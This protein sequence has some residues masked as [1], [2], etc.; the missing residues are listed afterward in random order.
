MHATASVRDLETRLAA[1]EAALAEAENAAGTAR[2]QAALAQA[3][4]ARAQ[5]ALEAAEALVLE[6]LQRPAGLL[7]DDAETAA[8]VSPPT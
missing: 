1:A 4:R 3:E 5:A 8:A 2:E 6:R 7:L